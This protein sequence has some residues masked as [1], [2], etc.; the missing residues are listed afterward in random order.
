M[1]LSARGEYACLAMIELAK[2][3][4]RGLLKIEQ[5]AERERIPK[6]YLEQILLALKHAGYLRSLR[7][8]SGGY[9]LSRKPAS[10]SVAEIVIITDGPLAPVNSASKYFYSHTPS[11]NNRPLS[12]LFREI[13]DMVAKK[14]EETSFADL[15]NEK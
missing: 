4:G 11:E 8:A 13:R 12:R 14:M 15:A 5:I 9:E 3:H 6:K 7:G 10:I 2:H 1:K